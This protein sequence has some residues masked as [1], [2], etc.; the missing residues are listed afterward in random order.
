ITL[1][2]ISDP[3][4]CDSRGADLTCQHKRCNGKWD[5]RDLSLVVV[6]AQQSAD[7][8]EE[9]AH[10]R[11]S[12]FALHKHIQQSEDYGHDDLY[13]RRVPLVKFAV[14]A[15]FADLVP[16]VCGLCRLAHVRASL[17]LQ[18]FRWYI[19]RFDWLAD[20]AGHWISSAFW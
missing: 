7:Q 14:V 16:F 11:E 17:R 8:Q 6:E 19:E 9:D 15:G 1:E 3:G 5:L 18:D 13:L 12:R 20:I 2:L 4:G 10:C